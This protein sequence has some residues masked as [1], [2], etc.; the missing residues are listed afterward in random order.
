MPRGCTLS[1]AWW[2]HCRSWG[3]QRALLDPWL[4]SRPAPSPPEQH[5]GKGTLPNHLDELSL[6]V[7]NQQDGGEG[8]SV[9]GQ[10]KTRL[11]ILL[12]AAQQPLLAC[13]GICWG[14][15]GCCSVPSSLERSSA[16]STGCE[17]SKELIGCAAATRICVYHQTAIRRNFA[18]L[19]P[20]FCFLCVFHR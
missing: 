3:G 7:T 18:C 20:S 2:Q 15:C 16:S 1:G 13:R 11:F 12:A 6:L 14:F 19:L 10:R 4:W 17:E 8:S 9:P 5:P